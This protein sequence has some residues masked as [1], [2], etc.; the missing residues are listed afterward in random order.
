MMGSETI[1]EQVKRVCFGV[2]IES[3]E[4][5]HQNVMNELEKLFIK[6]GYI[7]CREYPI[8]FDSIARKSR[9]RISRNGY[10]DMAAIKDGHRIAIEFDSGVN[11]KFKSIEK[12]FQIDADLCIGI[13]RGKS[14]KLG[15]CL[16]KIVKLVEEFNFLGGNFWVISLAEKETCNVSGHIG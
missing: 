4:G 2:D 5:L 11:L 3:R 9:E 12:L 15:F 8:R 13:V 10:V 14:E 16:E 6:G 7:V 1:I